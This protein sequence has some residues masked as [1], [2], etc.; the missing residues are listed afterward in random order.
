MFK[1][2]EMVILGLVNNLTGR[3]H[4]SAKEED[5]V[6]WIVGWTCHISSKNEIIEMSN[7]GLV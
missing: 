1:C 3:K 4:N 2:A 7:Q 6:F 5:N